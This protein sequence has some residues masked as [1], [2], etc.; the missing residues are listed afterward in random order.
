MIT[1]WKIDHKDTGGS[2]LTLEQIDILVLIERTG[3]GL[4]M[5]AIVIIILS[6]IMMSKL[7]TTPNLFLFYA[8][9]ANLG[10]SVASM[11]GYDGLNLGQ[12]SALCQAQSFIFQWYVNAETR[13]HKRMRII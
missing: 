2:G 4:S 9:I 3:A 11:I 7:R 8:A 1:P 13:T 5:V 12:E 6:F 10:A